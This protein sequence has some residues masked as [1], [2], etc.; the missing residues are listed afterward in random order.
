MS[1]QKRSQTTGITRRD[2]I[3]ISMA[4]TALAGCSR[5]RG[6]T[7]IVQGNEPNTQ[8]NATHLPMVTSDVPTASNI[9]SSGT[10][11]S[12]TSALA[13][14]AVNRLTFGPRAGD[15][16]RVARMGLSAFIDEQLNMPASADSGN[17]ALNERLAALDVLGASPADIRTKYDNKRSEVF[18]QM[19]TA[20]ILRATYSARQL[21]ELIV[22]FW[23]NHF[24]IFIGKGNGFILKPIDDREV[25]RKYALGK[26]R[27]LLG[28]SAHSPAMLFYLDNQ[29]NRKGK[30]DENYA[31]ELLELHTLGVEGG[32]G[33][34][35]V[36]ELSRA[37][38]G[39]SISGIDSDQPGA[40]LY[41]PNIHDE[42]AK[43]ILGLS[44]PARGGMGDVEKVL[45]VLAMHPNTMK[46][47]CGKIARRFIS[48]TPS[49]SGAVQKG[50]DAWKASDGDMKIVFSAML[51]SDEFMQSFGL[52]FRR[53]FEFVVSV[54]RALD[55]NVTVGRQMLDYFRQMG[56]PLFFWQPPNGYPD[57]KGA[58]FESSSLLARWNFSLQIASNL[59]AGNTWGGGM[60]TGKGLNADQMID[61]ASQRLLGATLPA[62]TKATLTPFAN[63]RQANILVALMLASPLYQVRS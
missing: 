11:A 23:T 9:N 26:F 10:S 6:S 53:P 3:K 19:Q 34:K 13:W 50:I 36:A 56:Q 60:I 61:A 48:D 55:A 12:T 41:R 20:A 7:R 32:Y 63:E 47:V 33:E 15:V 54:C 37:L 40:F 46:Y 35:D 57:V 2:L 45:D 58:W 59:L 31:R 30:P 16:D 52:K 25:I 21:Y 4:M 17:K 8:P 1:Q 38:T 29:A 44:L 28:A 42:G 22:D 27:D 18:A 43:T 39:W 51:N 24:N 14:L 5:L 49:A 62:P